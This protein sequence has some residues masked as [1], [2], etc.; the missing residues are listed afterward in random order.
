[1]GAS[2]SASTDVSVCVSESVGDQRG[3]PRGRG[4]ERGRSVLEKKGRK[5]SVNKDEWIEKKAKKMRNLGKEYTTPRSKKTVRARQIGPPCQDGCFEKVNQDARNAIFDRFW[6]MGD[7]DTQNGYLAQHVRAVPVKR[8]RQKES[9]RVNYE[10][11]LKY[12]DES[13]KVCRKA[14]LSI[15]DISDKRL[16]IHIQ[17]IKASATGTPKGDKRGRGPS[18]TKIIGVKREHVHEHIQSLPTTSSHYTRAKSPHRTFLEAGTT[19][20]QLFEKYQLWMREYHSGEPVVNYHYYADVFTNEYNIGVKPPKKDTCSTCDAI[21][22]SIVRLREEDEDTA[23]LETKLQEHKERGEMVQRLLSSQVDASPVHGMDVRVVCMDLQQTLPC[24]RVTSGMAY[25]L[26]KLWVYN[27]CIYDVTKGKASMFVWDEV[28]GGR[29]SDEVASII[30][31]WLEMRQREE[32]GDFDILR[33]FCDNCAGQN[34]NI[35]VLLAALRLVHAKMI[36]RVEFV[37]MVSGHS[38]LPCDRAFGVIE[39]K[40]RTSSG[41]FIPEHYADVIKKATNPPYEVITLNRED[42]K[43]IKKLSAF[44]TKRQTPVSFAKASQ[45]VV[46]VGYKEGYIIKT[47]YSFLDTEENAHRCRLM[48]TNK[49]YSAKLFDLSAVPLTEKYPDERR[50]NPVKV[51]DLQKLAQF[52]GPASRTWTLNVVQ[53][54]KEMAAA[55]QPISAAD[56]EEVG[57]DSENDLIDYDAPVQSPTKRK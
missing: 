2:T 48:K 34:K 10:Y 17:R 11:T 39:K 9:T 24:P 23:A 16:Q 36:N 33:I 22:A 57:S 3:R 46:D 12:F 13:F 37:F 19:I 43:D 47:D 53:R 40:L 31:K 45:L 44:V 41:I 21:Q 56:D 8:R 26:R 7:Y 20:K 14:F 32:D 51:D 27:F 49:R 29:G 38:Y 30:M 4:R 6:S 1:M 15:H 5:R 52:M 54:Q 28:T 25:Y 18:A 50:L 42:F 35:N 55:N